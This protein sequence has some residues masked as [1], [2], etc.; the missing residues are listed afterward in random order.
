MC[1]ITLSKLV[2]Y[3]D[4]GETEENKEVNF[5]PCFKTYGKAIILILS[6]ITL[7]SLKPLYQY[8]HVV[9]VWFGM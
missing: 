5:I 1:D 8:S 4:W 2:I 6:F 9:F 7:C 3:K